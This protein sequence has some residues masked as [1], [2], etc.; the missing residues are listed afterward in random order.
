MTLADVEAEHGFTFGGK[1]ESA[2]SPAVAAV[3]CGTPGCANLGHHVQVHADTPLP[4]HCGACGGVL[5]CEHDTEPVTRLEGTVQAPV[6]V[7]SDVCKVCGL[8][9]NVSRAELP[10]VDVAGLP[11]SAFAAHIG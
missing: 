9:S 1:G 11:A 8:E 5:L 2:G 10:A 6:R 3:V 4:V 7:T